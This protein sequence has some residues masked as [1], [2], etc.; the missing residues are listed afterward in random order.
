MFKVKQNAMVATFA[1]SVAFSLLAGCASTGPSNPDL[2]TPAEGRSYDRTVVI[3]L[4]TKWVNVNGGEVVK[5]V[6]QEPDGADKSFTWRFD[7]SR[8][9]VGDLSKLA[10]SG[11]LGRPV[12]VFVAP[13]PLYLT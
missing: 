13:N 2:V 10:P 11:V 1:A 7:T 6:V 9:T 8:E 4:N 5:F 3:E 12:K